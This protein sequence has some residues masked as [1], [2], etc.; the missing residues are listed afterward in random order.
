M[1]K[2]LDIHPRRRKLQPGEHESNPADVADVPSPPAVP[3]TIAME[4]K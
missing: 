1:I 3:L 4:E 2:R